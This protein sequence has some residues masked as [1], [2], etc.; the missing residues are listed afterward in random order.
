MERRRLPI[1]WDGL[2]LALTWPADKGGCWLDLATG[3]VI[4]WMGPADENVSSDDIDDGLAEGRLIAIDSIESKVRYDWMAEFIASL[5]HASLRRDLDRA[6]AG[7][8]PFRAFKDVLLDHPS[9]R[10]RWF[11]FET[12]RVRQHAREWLEDEGIEPTTEPP[13]RG[14]S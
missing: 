10:E 12:E 7:R 2:E 9:D 11:A 8:R 6:L 13:R 14:T 4:R 3:E 5:T 1:D